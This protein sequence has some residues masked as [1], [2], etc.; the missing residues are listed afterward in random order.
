MNVTLPQRDY[1]TLSR[2]MVRALDQQI[3]P[4]VSLKLREEGR[5]AGS[6]MAD[7]ARHLAG[8]RSNRRRLLQAAMEVLWRRGFEPRRQDAV[9]VLGNCPFEAVAREHPKV[10]CEMNIAILEGFVGKLHIKGTTA[11]L[12]PED[13]RCCVIVQTG[14]PAEEGAA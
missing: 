2:L 7:E 10:V 14:L 13:G 8:R 1:E 4:A 9:I 3:P 12:A 11:R 6:V 5:N